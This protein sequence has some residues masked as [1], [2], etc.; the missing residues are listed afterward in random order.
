MLGWSTRSERPRNVL[1][2]CR[3]LNSADLE[4]FSASGVVLDQDADSFHR[5]SECVHAG[6]RTG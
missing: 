6:Y 2:S 5:R 4:Y 3:H 1:S